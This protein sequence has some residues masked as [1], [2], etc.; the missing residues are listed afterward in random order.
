MD[1]HRENGKWTGSKSRPLVLMA[2]KPRTKTFL[3]VGYEYPETSGDL[4]KN[5]FGKSFELTAQS[6]NGSFRFDS[7]E[8]NVVEVARADVQRFIEQLH[9]LMDNLYQQ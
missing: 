7:F 1:L 4:V 6:M 5:R 9:Y 8:S 2:E 3:V